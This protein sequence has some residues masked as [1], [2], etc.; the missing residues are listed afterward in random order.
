M[1][2]PATVEEFLTVVTKSKLLGDTSLESYLHQLSATPRLPD[3]LAEQMV[4]DGFLTRFQVDNLLQGKWQRFYV[5]PYKVLE[6]IGSGSSGAVYLC[7]DHRLRRRVAIKVLSRTKAQDDECLRRF[8][9]EARAAAALDHPNIVRAFD[10]AHED[11]LHYLVMEFVDGVSLRQLVQSQGLLTPAQ[12]ADFMRQAA[13]GLHH[14]HQAGLVHRDVKPSNLVLHRG[15]IIKILDLGLAR[16]F[17]DDDDLTRGAVLGTVGLIAPEQAL[18]SHNADA[19]T[20]VYALGATFFL[21]LTG[22]RPP[23]QGIV[24]RGPLPRLAEGAS[25]F[26]FLM[27]VIRRMI[28]A[29][30]EK[31]YQTAEEVAE[32][33]APWALPLFDS[34][35]NS[36]NA[37]M[38]NAV[39]TTLQ[40]VSALET[41]PPAAPSTTIPSPGFSPASN[42]VNQ[43]EDNRKTKPPPLKPNRFSWRKV[44][45]SHWFWIAALA[46]SMVL[47]VALV[48]AFMG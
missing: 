30:P 3:D 17:E 6:K 27:K 20:D 19:R 39:F 28:A 25:S 48:Y 46:G 38:G 33:L 42:D 11:N 9:R 23:P 7:E 40:D 2:A 43:A 31:R 15:K 35:A 41:E 22:E 36:N 16:F 5:G 47:L 14:A 18:H 1:P 24:G 32:A 12:A 21:L 37:T 26:K 4:R 44:R 8:E 10:V 29:L 45:S 13:L 34:P